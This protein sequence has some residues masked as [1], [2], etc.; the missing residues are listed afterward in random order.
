ME[1]LEGVDQISAQSEAH[2]QVEGAGIGMEA[3]REQGMEPGMEQ[4]MGKG[5]EQGMGRLRQSGVKIQVASPSTMTAG[6]G[7][8]A[9]SSS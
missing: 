9:V 8:S 1:L 2:C 4:G 7:D 3:G 5:R 6:A